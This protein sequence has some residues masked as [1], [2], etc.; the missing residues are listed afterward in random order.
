MIGL[1]IL[2]MGGALWMAAVVGHGYVNTVEWIAWRLRCHARRVRQMH[3]KQA[4]VMDDRWAREM[5][6]LI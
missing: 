6:E 4:A 2:A 1:I 5:K 3:Q